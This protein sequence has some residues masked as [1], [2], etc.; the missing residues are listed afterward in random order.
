MNKPI[1]GP[2]EKGQSGNPKGRPKEGCSWATIMTAA[3]EQTQTIEKIGSDGKVTKITKPRKDILVEIL[4][5]EALKGNMTALEKIFDRTEGKPHQSM[6]VV[7]SVG[8]TME[9]L[10]DEQAEADKERKNGESRKNEN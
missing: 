9:Q 5:Q 4:I 2:W 7:S 10:L 1:T 8:V 6:D 3:L